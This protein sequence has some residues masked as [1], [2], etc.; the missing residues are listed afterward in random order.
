MAQL[1]AVFDLQNWQVHMLQANRQVGSSILQPQQMCL[2]NLCSN[3]CF[4]V[5]GLLPASL[6]CLGVRHKQ[7]EANDRAREHMASHS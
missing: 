4:A 1:I 3:R 7:L 6:P 2:E 5:D